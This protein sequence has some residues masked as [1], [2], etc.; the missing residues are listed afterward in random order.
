MAR[1]VRGALRLLRDLRWRMLRWSAS[2]DQRYHDAAFL[3]TAADPFSPAYPGSITIRRF[4][5]LAEPY[6]RDGT[7]VLDLGCG[8]G[9]ITC[10]LAR[11][12]P[13]ARFIGVDHSRQAL[14]IAEAHAARLGVSNVSFTACDV[15]SYSPPEPPA[16]VLMF[17]AFHHLLDPAA[18]VRRFR[19]FAC[20]F[21]LIEPVG[22]ALGR[23]R[24]SLDFDWVAAELDRIRA[25]LDYEFGTPVP[26]ARASDAAEPAGEPVEHRYTLDDFE[27]FFEGFTLT[28]RGTVSGLN[29]YPVPLELRTT[30]REQFGEIAQTIYKAIDDRL[31]AENRDLW[32]RHWVVHAKPGPRS[33]RRQPGPFTTASTPATTSPVT[34]AYDVMYEPYAGPVEAP[35]KSEVHTDITIRNAGYMRWSSDD[36]PP[37]FVSY[38]WLTRSGVPIPQEGRRSRLPRPLD[39]GAACR[40]PIVIETPAEEGRYVLE[41]DLVH[42]G[43]AWFS[44]AGQMPCRTPFRVVGR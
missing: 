5:D 29:S 6:V 7:T 39:P 3:D 2:D 9:E 32:G 8:P 12:R 20:E 15:S 22:D 14:T 43:V 35:S 11:R 37:V 16:L 1:L 13:L 21:L 41:I 33:E 24:D 30:W 4:A 26:R 38:R 27:S 42:E 40:V 18:F 23:W 31:L 19:P 36:E 10:E 34:G 25:R 28:I 17:N 44:Q